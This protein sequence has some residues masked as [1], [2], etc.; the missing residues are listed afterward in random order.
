M[1]LLNLIGAASGWEFSHYALFRVL[2]GVYLLAHF[3]GLA[4]WVGELFS[5]GGMLVDGSSSPAFSFPNLL[6]LSDSPLSV[7]ILNAT[8][9]IAAVAF[10]LGVGDKWAALW[11]WLVLS[12]FLARNPLISN[13]ALPYVGW[14]LLAHLFVPAKSRGWHMPAAVLAATWVVLALS[15]TYSGYTKLLSPTWMAGDAVAVVLENPLARDW[16]ITV[17][18]AG[19]PDW[20]LKALTWFILW[21]ELLYAPLFL[22]RRARCW[23]WVSMLFVQFGF[24][25]LLKFPD[26]TTPMLLMHFLACEPRW[27]LRLPERVRERLGASLGDRLGEK[28]RP[29][30]ECSAASD[31]WWMPDLR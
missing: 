12:A 5:S 31:R 4:P 7:S 13:P 23:L 25:A 17:L 15:Y 6:W 24:L 1:K 29:R 22:L 14:M 28:I 8:A 9:G 2:L 10:I 3:V 19:L 30:R 16:W 11:I 20:V 26:L 18:L 27:F 21:V